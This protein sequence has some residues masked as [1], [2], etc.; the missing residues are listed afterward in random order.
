[1]W[2][3][4]CGLGCYWVVGWSGDGG[5]VVGLVLGMVVAY[6]RVL[7]TWL[8]NFFFFWYCDLP[9]SQLSLS[10]THSFALILSFLWVYKIREMLI[11]VIRIL[12][13]NFLRKFRHHFYEK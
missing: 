3:G 8:Q 11:T 12:V 9:L 2:C 4:F 7:K 6:S 10:L 13:N 5:V 1:M